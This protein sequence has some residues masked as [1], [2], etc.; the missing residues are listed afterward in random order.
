M[1]KSKAKKKNARPVSSATNVDAASIIEDEFGN[2]RIKAGR[3]NGN[4]IARAFPKPGANSQGLM[5][6]AGGTSEEEAI[7]ALKAMLTERETQRTA[8]RRWEARSEIQVPTHEEFV[9]ALRQ[10]NLSANQRAMLKAHAI[11]GAD[12]ITV[13]SLM[14]AGGYKSKDT[15]MKVF[16]RAGVLL[17]DFLG[18]VV[19]QDD[20][21]GPNTAARVMSFRLGEEPETTARWVMHEE[22]RQAVRENL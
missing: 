3:L 20:A 19:A 4:Y 7:A 9:E 2:Y 11:A 6:E 18:A 1:A 10:T 12:G 13:I 17:A 8:A 5:A 22:L 14:N 15:A 21:S 16:E